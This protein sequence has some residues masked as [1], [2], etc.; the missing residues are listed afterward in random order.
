MCEQSYFLDYNLG[1]KS[2]SGK[3]ADLGTNTHKVMEILAGIKLSIQN[4]EQFYIDDILGSIDV[5]NYKLEDITNRVFEHYKALFNHHVWTDKDLKTCH[6][7]V[8]TMITSHNGVFDPRNREIVSSEGHFDIIIDKPWADYEYEINGEILKGKLGIKGTIDLIT[9]ANDETLEIVDLKG[10]PLKT[11]IPTPNG[12]TNMKDIKVGD[13]LF[14]Q[15][16]KVCKVTKKSKVKIKPCYKITFDDKTS[17]VCDDEHLWSLSDGK[18]KCVTDLTIDDKINVCKPVEYEKQNLPIEPYLLGL[19]LGDGRNRNA[20]ITVGD[21]DLETLNNITNRGHKLGKLYRY[22][23]RKCIQITVLD[24]TH[25]LRELNLLHNKHIPDIY[26]RS[27][28]EQRLELL[29]GLM[30]SDGNVNSVRKQAVF[31]NCCEKLSNDVKELLLSMGQR[32]YQYKNII[33]TNFK[34]NVTLYTIYFRPININPFL[35][36]RK[37]E[38]IKSDWGPG[39]SSVRKIIKIEKYKKRK[40]QC[41][42]V[43]SEDNTYLCTKNFIPTHNTG[44]RLDWATGEEKTIE[45]LHDDAQLRIYHYAVSK[46]YPQYE[47]IIVTIN[48]INDGGPFSVLFSK[49]DLAKTEEMLRKKFLTIKKCKKPKLTRSWKCTKLCYYGKNTFEN[50]PSVLPILEYRDDQVCKQGEFMT[51]CEQIKHEIELNGMKSVVDT[52]TAEGYSVGK[53]KPPGVA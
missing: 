2:P 40:T 16:G 4:N 18:I 26:L 31:N 27:S 1:I 5:N 10:L 23:D 25:K 9:K 17:V 47:Y 42:A 44:R 30:D 53:Y 32:P 33:D 49:E 52:Y 24:T 36:K 48:F 41:I 28:F 51:M 29:R 34:N 7:N 38:R 35:L 37:A 20:E 21:Q 15:Y 6:Q 43:D 46:M 22:G 39:K 50:H 12:W 45:K 14:D 19:W 8:N 13:E 11:P 3:K